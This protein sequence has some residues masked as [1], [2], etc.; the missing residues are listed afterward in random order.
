MSAQFQINKFGAA[1]KTGE[2][3][4]NGS[5]SNNQQGWKITS[6]VTLGQ[7]NFSDKMFVLEIGEPGDS[8]N[9]IIL[10]QSG[11]PVLGGKGYT[12]SFE[13]FA[14]G[15]R[16]MGIKV[17]ADDTVPLLDTIITLPTVPEKRSF[18]F[19]PDVD[20]MARVEF[21]MG[22]ARAG[23]FIDNV[24]FFTGPD[25]SGVI[26]TPLVNAT[27][28]RFTA[29][30]TGNGVLFLLPRGVTGTVSVYN[31]HGMLLRTLTSAG[32]VLWDGKNS[33]GARVARGTCI[34]TLTGK[35]T[36]FATKFVVR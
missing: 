7:T 18:K 6:N 9:D 35:N 20:A 28:G 23:I 11:L 30:S 15:T 3:I 27:N 31:L 5:F 12:F 19:T 22:G 26:A 17:V 14:N 24:S 25:P 2:L 34:V 16:T 29:L 4:D 13:A 21:Q 33:R 10:S 8:L 36:R 32:Q 1:V